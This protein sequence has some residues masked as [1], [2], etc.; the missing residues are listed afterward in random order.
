MFKKE[1]IWRGLSMVFALLLRISIM[2]A[3]ILE[4]YRTS[5][6][7]FVGTRSQQI[8]TEELDSEEDTW[9]YKSEFTSAQEAYDGLQEFAIISSAETYALLKNDN[10]TLPIASNAKS[11][12]L[13]FAAMHQYMEMM[14][15]VFQTENQP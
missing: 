12:Y 10:G 6:D 7:A 11:H 1:N 2:A 9:T 5:V 14:V 13:V 4:I 8:V 15:V 3:N